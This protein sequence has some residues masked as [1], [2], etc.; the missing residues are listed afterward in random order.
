MWYTATSAS[1]ANGATVIAVT[2][3][4]DISII[5]EDSGL[6]FEGESPVQVKRGYI[7]GSGDK[8]IELASPWPYTAKTNQPLVAYPTDASF[9]EATA[10]LRR[11]IDT[12]SVASTVEAQTG[13]DDEKIMTALKTKQ[14]I[15]F[16]TGTAASRDV[17]ANLASPD[18]Q[19]LMPVGYGGW[20]SPDA[21]TTSGVDFSAR[22]PMA[23]YPVNIADSTGDKPEQ[24][25]FG[26]VFSIA[27]TTGNTSHQ[28]YFSRN[29]NQDRL[30]YRT[31]RN[32]GVD[33]DDWITIFDSVNTNFNEFGGFQANDIIAVGYAVNASVIQFYIPINSN[34]QATSVTITGELKV[35]TAAGGDLITGITSA[36]VLPTSSNRV[37][38]LQLGY[39]GAVGTNYH[40]RTS[41]DASKIT[42]N[43]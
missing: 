27:G 17:A 18:T 20:G 16:N 22:L 8:F 39:A 11:V 9:A 5:Q 40:L 36:S 1:I 10:E 28:L 35:T 37:I 23:V 31:K 14:A 13:T 29:L 38:Q 32:S 12:L 42:V 21:G 34:S 24:N 15:D 7:D 4:D 25:G 43:F 19:K 41:T 33:Y 2:T 30:K 26:T 6:I 3:G